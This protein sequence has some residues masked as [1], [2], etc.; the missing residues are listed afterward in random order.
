MYYH[1]GAS[2]FPF[3]LNYV[4]RE[5][6]Y[7]LLQKILIIANAEHDFFRKALKLI[8]LVKRMKRK[9]LFDGKKND[10]KPYKNKTE[11]LF[12][13][14]NVSRQKSTSIRNHVLP[15]LRRENHIKHRSRIFLLTCLCS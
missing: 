6:K 13:K 1:S 3:D 14:F 10:K 5:K 9:G 2:L 4:S 7:N 11:F 8:S 12:S 15:K